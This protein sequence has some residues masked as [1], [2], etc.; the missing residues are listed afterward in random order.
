MGLELSDFSFVFSREMEK[1]AAG[2]ESIHY[3][4]NGNTTGVVERERNNIASFRQLVWILVACVNICERAFPIF[5]CYKIAGL[6]KEGK[7]QQWR[8]FHSGV[9]LNVITVKGTVKRISAYS[10]ER[11]YMITHQ[12]S[13]QENSLLRIYSMMKQSKIPQ[14]KD[15]RKQCDRRRTNILRITPIS[16]VFMRQT[17]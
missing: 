16:C 10:Q 12:D 11:T 3:P 5:R 15:S 2:N 14:P 8:V 7:Q 4:D 6:F 9:Y 17:R 13:L 1:G